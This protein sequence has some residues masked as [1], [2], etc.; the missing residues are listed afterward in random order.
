MQSAVR[1]TKTAAQRAVTKVPKRCATTGRPDGSHIPQDMKGKS[2]AEIQRWLAKRAADAQT[3]ANH[4]S[5][6][7]PKPANNECVIL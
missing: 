1:L 4:T 6:H 5:Q 3:H 7:T 2:E